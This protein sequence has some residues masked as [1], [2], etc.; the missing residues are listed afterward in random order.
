MSLGQK[1][2]AY[3]AGAILAFCIISIFSKPLS[4]CEP[5]WRYNVFAEPMSGVIKFDGKTMAVHRIC[6]KATD[7]GFLLRPIK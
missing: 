5:H 4:G 7:G 2:L 6:G 1:I 3:V